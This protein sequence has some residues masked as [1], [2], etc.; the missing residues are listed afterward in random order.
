MIALENNMAT[1]KSFRQPLGVLNIGMVLV[2]VVYVGMG[3]MGYWQYGD[4]IKSSITMNFP[5][6]EM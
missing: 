6:T 5:I 4:G 1:P 2:T 3:M